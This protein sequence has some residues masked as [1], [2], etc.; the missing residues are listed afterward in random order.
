MPCIHRNG[1]ITGYVVSYTEVKEETYFTKNVSREQRN[2]E[3]SRLKPSTQYEL[4]VAAVNSVGT[5]PFTNQS[6]MANTSGMV[7]VPTVG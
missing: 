5:G 2:T 4:R 1:H 6:L 3:I 7:I